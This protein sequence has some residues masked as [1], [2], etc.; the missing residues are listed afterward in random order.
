MKAQ[1]MVEIINELKNTDPK[2]YRQV[3]RM[4]K[5]GEIDN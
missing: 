3:I 4:L 1:E 2:F 5:N